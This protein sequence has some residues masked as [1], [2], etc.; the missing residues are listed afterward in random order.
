MV[1]TEC[2]PKIYSKNVQNYEIQRI[3]RSLFYT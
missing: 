3:F 1:K 2:K